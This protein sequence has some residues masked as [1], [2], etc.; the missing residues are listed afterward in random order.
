MP[1]TYSTLDQTDARRMI[2]AA[3]LAAE[4]TGVPYCIAVLDAGGHL[5]AFTRQDGALIGCIGLAIG[6]ARAARYSTTRPPSL[7]SSLNPALNCMGSNT[8]MPAPC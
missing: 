6:K 8:A 2:A 3:E 4:R 7:A 1:I 5:L